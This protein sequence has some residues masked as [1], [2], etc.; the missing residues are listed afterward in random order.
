[1]AIRDGNG[2]RRKC[3]D[4]SEHRKC[5]R[6]NTANRGYRVTRYPRGLQLSGMIRNGFAEVMMNNWSD[7]PLIR[8][9]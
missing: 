2:A 4:E 3:A 9:G 5:V 8:E 1:M 6:S 7:D